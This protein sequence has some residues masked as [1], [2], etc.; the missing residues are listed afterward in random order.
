MRKV[1]DSNYLRNPGLRAYL[2]ASQ[3][4]MAVL[5]DYAS[6]EAYKG[7]TLISIYNSMAILAEFPSQ[8][9]V[10]KNTL[11][12]CGLTGRG[13][14]LQRRFIDEAQTRDFGTY[15]RHLAV[16]KAGNVRLQR[17]LLDFGQEATQHLEKRML[18]DAGTFPEVIELIAANYTKEELVALRTAAPYS[19]AMVKKFITSVLQV[20]LTMFQSHP[21]VQNI[22]NRKEVPNTFVFRAALCA[23]LLALDW[24][25]MAGP[26]GAK[27]ASVKRLRND[28]VD[29]NFAAYATYF[30]GLLSCDGK[31]R[32]IHDQARLFLAKV[33]GCHISGLAA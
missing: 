22:P 20:S 8:V 13:A 10:L 14:G 17:Q 27:G 6:M 12:A 18:A 4:N 21:R 1:V 9:L 33:S 26:Q 31:T 28:I 16:A 2:S 30:D 29:V 19:D 24:I 11:V 25:A 5:T 7:D 23:Y 3:H 32:R 15:C